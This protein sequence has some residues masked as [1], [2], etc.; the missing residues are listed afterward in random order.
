[1]D[2]PTNTLMNRLN[3]NI[4]LLFNQDIVQGNFSKP[5]K[6]RCVPTVFPSCIDTVKVH[7]RQT[8]NAPRIQLE[9][10]GH[11]PRICW[12]VHC[13]KW[14]PSKFFGNQKVIC[15]H[16]DLWPF[17][18]SQNYNRFVLVIYP[19]HAPSFVRIRH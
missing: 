18:Y 6:P 2:S 11:T 1:M 16:G 7:R 14:K 17:G 3:P 9:Q 5:L 15:R 12:F 13:G 4:N 10:S 8:C 19:T